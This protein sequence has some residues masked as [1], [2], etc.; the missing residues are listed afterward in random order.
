MP[1]ERTFS[2]RISCGIVTPADHVGIDADDEDIGLLGRKFQQ[3]QMPGMNNVKV[4]GDKRYAF[5]IAASHSDF[6]RI[7]RFARG[8]VVIQR[9]PRRTSKPK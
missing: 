4:A 3:P 6:A 9:C 1:I 8:I 2:S 5:V 7:R